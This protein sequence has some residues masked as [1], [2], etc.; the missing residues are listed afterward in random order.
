MTHSGGSV[1]QESADGKTIYYLTSDAEAP[2]ALRAIAVSGG[3]ERAL[4]IQILNRAFQVMTDG[5]YFIAPAVKDGGGPEIRFYDFASRHSHLIQPLGNVNLFVGFAVSPDRKS[6]LY[7]VR[8]DKGRNLMLV[9]KF[10]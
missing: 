5:I 6:F 1:P 10:R 4:G 7:T 3:Q 8:V 9:N 2:A